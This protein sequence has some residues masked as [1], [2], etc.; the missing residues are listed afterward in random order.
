ME[1]NKN[2]KWNILKQRKI[3][4]CFEYFFVSFLKFCMEKEKMKYVIPI[5]SLGIAAV[6]IAALFALLPSLGFFKDAVAANQEEAPTETS[7]PVLTAEEPEYAAKT[8]EE[9]VL[10]VRVKH[11][12][13]TEQDLIN[14]NG[15][16]YTNEAVQ[17]LSDVDK[18]KLSRGFT[19]YQKYL[20]MS[21]VF[22][23]Y[24]DVKEPKDSERL[25]ILNE[26]AKLYLTSDISS[27]VKYKDELLKKY[28]FEDP[29]DYDIAGILTDVTNI[30]D[31]RE[32][33]NTEGMNLKELYSNRRGA[34]TAIID[35]LTVDFSVVPDLIVDMK[36][37][38]P[39]NGISEVT[40]IR[41]YS[42]NDT[43]VPNVTTSKSAD[44]LEEVYFVDPKGLSWVGYVQD[45][46]GIK[47]V[48]SF[49]LLTQNSSS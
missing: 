6:G 35:C 33:K 4:S 20:T 24:K 11:F 15:L 16:G 40:S 13:P 14:L 37:Q 48:V 9:V 3:V 31:T 46:N 5:I 41:Y 2:E 22:S 28:T 49:R 29:Q 39:V 12:T 43:E 8:D 23:P 45:I 26:I 19:E 44:L 21:P 25:P 47:K 7:A 42:R 36:S 18:V 27:V 32:G 1:N 38:Y 34:V 10:G 17:N 30:S